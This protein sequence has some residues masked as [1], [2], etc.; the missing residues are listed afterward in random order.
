MKLV[1]LNTKL[2]IVLRWRLVWC[3]LLAV[4]PHDLPLETCHNLQSRKKRDKLGMINVQRCGWQSSEALARWRN[5]A[6]IM[7]AQGIKNGGLT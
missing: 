4:K 1:F 5:T 7:S 2:N 6:L 3:I